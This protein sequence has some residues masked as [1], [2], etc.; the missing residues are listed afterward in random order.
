LLAS[1]AANDASS[2]TGFGIVTLILGI[3]LLIAGF[4]SRSGKRP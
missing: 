3:V 2:A 4:N 1:G